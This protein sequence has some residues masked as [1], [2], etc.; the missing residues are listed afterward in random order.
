M[1]AEEILSKYGLLLRHTSHMW[2]SPSGNGTEQI[3]QNG[4]ESFFNSLRQL[5]QRIESFSKISPHI[6]H[7]FG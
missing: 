5:L 3:G 6:G 7:L 4:G 1:Y 2:D